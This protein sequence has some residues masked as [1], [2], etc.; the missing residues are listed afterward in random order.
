MEG[1]KFAVVAIVFVFSSNNFLWEWSRPS[2]DDHPPI[3][4]QK[5]KF[6]PLE[7]WSKG[8]V[9]SFGNTVTKT[10]PITVARMAFCLWH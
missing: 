9:D 2:V 3:V 6:G 10:A 5:G 8:T 4:T 7:Y 1:M